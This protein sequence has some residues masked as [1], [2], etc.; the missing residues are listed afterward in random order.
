MRQTLSWFPAGDIATLL[1]AGEVLE[2]LIQQLQGTGTP[3]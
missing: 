1:A 3:K 2:R